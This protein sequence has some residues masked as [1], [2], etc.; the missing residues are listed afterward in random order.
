[1]AFPRSNG[2]DP[3]PANDFWSPMDQASNNARKWLVTGA[4]AVGVAIGAA[5]IAAAATSTTNG[6]TSPTTSAARSSQ[7]NENS[8]HEK[9]ESAQREADEKAGRFGPGGHGFG[10]DG[11]GNETVVTGA[12]ADKIKAAALAAVPGTLN[13]AEQ[14]SDGTYEAEIT[15]AD[16]SEVH[17]SLDK[18]FKVTSTNARGA[19]DFGGDRRHDGTPNMPNA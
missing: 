9:S 8:T 5:G 16:G 13:K 15:K 18:N 12:T 3:H 6:S 11:H 4:L 2:F 17:V 14:R 1:M 10:R 19:H 7:G